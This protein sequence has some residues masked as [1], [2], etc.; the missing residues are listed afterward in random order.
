[1]LIS[2]LLESFRTDLHRVTCPLHVFC[3]S[4]E[5]AERFYILQGILE[6]TTKRSQFVEAGEEIERVATKIKKVELR[7][8]IVGDQHVF[9]YAVDG[10]GG[11]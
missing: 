2:D 3:V 7:I 11:S 5:K 6:F 4:L 10:T 9:L 8:A 1:M